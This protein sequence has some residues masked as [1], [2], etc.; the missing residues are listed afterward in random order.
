MRQ[1]TK[2]R[3]AEA[4][5]ARIPIQ[6][7]SRKATARNKGNH[8]TSNMAP[9]T[10]LPIACRTVSKSRMAW[11]AAFELRPIIR[12]RIFGASKAS[13][14]RLALTRRR[15]RIASSADRAN[16]ATANARV[17]N[18]SVIL[19]PVATTRS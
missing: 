4:A 8:G 13:S 12:F 11:T 2:N 16:K 7:C 19:P 17:M 1:A 9:A 14:L 10:G 15:F 5:V 18:S 3:I 6:K